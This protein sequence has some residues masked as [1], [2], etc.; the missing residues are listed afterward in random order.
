MVRVALVGSFGF[1]YFTH[2][3]VNL[4]LSPFLAWEFKQKRFGL[5]KLNVSPLLSDIPL[6]FHDLI[7]FFPCVFFFVF[8]R[9]F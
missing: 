5:E 3:N 7:H 9:W 2:L 1:D 6:L 8:S 4:E